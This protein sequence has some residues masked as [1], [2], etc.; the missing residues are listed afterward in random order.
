MW[1]AVIAVLGSLL[2]FGFVLSAEQHF[3]AVTLG[4]EGERL[5]QEAEGLEE[6]LNRLEYERARATTPL[7]L[8]RRARSLG[9]QRPRFKPGEETPHSGMKT[10]GIHR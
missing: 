5:R 8:E 1:L 7:E 3:E 9:L 6:R 4:Y 10:D 2:T